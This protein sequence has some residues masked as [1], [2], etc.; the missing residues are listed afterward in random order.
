M[1]VPWKEGIW[2]NNCL[3]QW[4]SFSKRSFLSIPYCRKVIN[5]LFFFNNNR[6]TKIRISSRYLFVHLSTFVLCYGWM[7]TNVWWNSVKSV[8]KNYRS[9][10][11]FLFSSKNQLREL[12]DINRTFWQFLIKSKRVIDQLYDKERN[13]GQTIAHNY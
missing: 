13:L 12:F 5:R 8:V 3:H 10:S 4:K 7:D 6:S 9:R 1:S 11:E 2:V